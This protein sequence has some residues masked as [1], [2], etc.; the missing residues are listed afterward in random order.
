MMTIRC[1]TKLSALLFCLPLGLCIAG[2]AKASSDDDEEWHEKAPTSKKHSADD[3]DSDKNADKN[4][5]KTARSNADTGSDNKDSQKGDD[6]SGKESRSAHTAT[7]SNSKL[8]V[9]LLGGWGFSS[10]LQPGLGLRAG[11]HLEEQQLP[12][13][14]GVIGEYF[15][16]TTTVTHT[17]G[18]SERTLRFTYVGVEGGLDIDATPDILVRPFF[19]LGLG[20]NT[21][22]VC[23]DG[24]P[25]S[26]DTSLHLTI[27]PGLLGLYQM[28]N[29]F[30]GA[31]LRY[32]IVA[33]ASTA[34]GAVASATIGLR[35]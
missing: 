17:Y 27:T 18:K 15:F 16:G 35:F 1:S 20:F 22:K 5:D 25:C 28:G 7:P 12:F 31:D 4:A 8:S 21:D 2:T 30:V 14:V 19:G 6:R 32:L 26:G 34:S 9:A 13:Y 3:S 29:L 24:S 33:G 11:A 10:P 23:V